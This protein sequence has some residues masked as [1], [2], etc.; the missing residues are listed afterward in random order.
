MQR[1]QPLRQR[2]Q[3]PADEQQQRY[4]GD[5]VPGH[6][7]P[8]TGDLPARDADQ[9]LAEESDHAKTRRLVTPAARGMDEGMDEKARDDVP[10][11]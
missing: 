7:S 6:A 1:R 4:R 9:Q 5:D 8:D 11:R 10:R 2:Q 3:K